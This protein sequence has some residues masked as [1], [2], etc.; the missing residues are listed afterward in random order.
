MN[1]CCRGQVLASFATAE[2]MKPT[3]SITSTR[4]TMVMLFAFAERALQRYAFRTT[5]KAALAVRDEFLAGSSPSNVR[6]PSF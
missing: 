3:R 2:L 5:L 4:F 6:E 1:R